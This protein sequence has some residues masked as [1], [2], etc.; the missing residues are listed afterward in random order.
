MAF[1][2]I[3][4][5]INLGVCW[6]HRPRYGC[7]SWPSTNNQGTLH[8]LS[9]NRLAWSHINASGALWLQRYKWS[10]VSK[11]TLQTLLKCPLRENFLSLMHCHGV[12]FHACT[13]LPPM[14]SFIH[15]LSIY[16]HFTLPGLTFTPLIAFFVQIMVPAIMPRGKDRM[17]Q[18]KYQMENAFS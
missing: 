18:A 7:L 1:L 14:N 11:I 8:P 6:K 12:Q 4:Y 15:L 3:S 16:L 13:K 2:T 17:C 5:L 10:L 9:T